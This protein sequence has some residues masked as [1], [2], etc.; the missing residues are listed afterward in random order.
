MEPTGT[1]ECPICGWAEP[2]H[3]SDFEVNVERFA[4]PAFEM[5]YA[6]AM[7]SRSNENSTADLSRNYRVNS[8][9]VPN[10]WALRLGKNS[11][12]K[13]CGPYHDEKVESYWQVFKAAWT[14]PPDRCAPWMLRF[15]FDSCCNI[16]DTHD[17]EQV[18][19]AFGLIW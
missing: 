6:L 12:G 3:H 4:R 7:R 15:R 2:H 13:P 14:C 9:G 1:L 17:P 5:W 10:R 16:I 18:A 19:N 11:W 8:W